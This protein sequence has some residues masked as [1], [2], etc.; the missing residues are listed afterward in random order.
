MEL[1][2]IW[3]SIGGRK[4]KRFKRKKSIRNIFTVESF[5]LLKPTN[6]F[7]SLFTLRIIS[8]RLTGQPNGSPIKSISFSFGRSPTN[9]KIKVGRFYI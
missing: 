4:V 5:N 7:T 1:D 3:R 2:L 9:V 6:L 8:I